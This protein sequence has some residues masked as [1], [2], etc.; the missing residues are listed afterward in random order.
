MVTVF[1]S[2]FLLIL[3]QKGTLVYIVSFVS[4]EL[5][6]LHVDLDSSCLEIE[7]SIT[8]LSYILSF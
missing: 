8:P 7:K 1:V 5:I 2:D 6:T 3:F 4:L